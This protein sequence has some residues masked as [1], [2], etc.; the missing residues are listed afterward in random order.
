M[1]QRGITH[2]LVFECS[3][4]HVSIRHMD[5]AKKDLVKWRT[6]CTGEAII[7]LKAAIGGSLLLL[8]YRDIFGFKLFITNQNL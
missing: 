8:F 6:T 5:A 7:P 3:A 1:L 4:F 2:R